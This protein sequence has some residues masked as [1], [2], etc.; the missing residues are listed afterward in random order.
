[1]ELFDYLR[2]Y[3]ITYIR[4]LNIQKIKIQSL[5]TLVKTKSMGQ[6]IFATSRKECAGSEVSKETAINYTKAPFSFFHFLNPLVCLLYFETEKTYWSK[7]MLVPPVRSAYCKL[8]FLCFVGTFIFPI[9]VWLVG[10]GTFCGQNIGEKWVDK[11]VFRVVGRIPPV[12]P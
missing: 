4:Y 11:P 6:L 12:P 9:R 5:H 3:N 7:F 8:V 1:M 10:G 2:I